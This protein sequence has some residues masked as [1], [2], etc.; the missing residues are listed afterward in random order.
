M[1]GLLGGW[2]FSNDGNL[3]TCLLFEFRFGNLLILM[4]CEPYIDSQPYTLLLYYWIEYKSSTYDKCCSPLSLMWLAGCV[5]ERTRFSGR[6]D[7]GFIS[8]CRCCF[9]LFRDK[10][11]CCMCDCID[12]HSYRFALQNRLIVYDFD[13]LETTGNCCCSSS[14]LPI[15]LVQCRVVCVSVVANAFLCS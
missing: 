2:R 13:Q 4:V 5:C 3:T 1:F 9:F 11:C 6:F 15:E 10:L 12:W 8:S 7:D 14:R